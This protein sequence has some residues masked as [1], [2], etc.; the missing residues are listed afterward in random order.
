M[1][2]DDLRKIVLLYRTMGYEQVKP[3]QWTAIKAFVSG[4]DVYVALPTGFVKSLIY[5]TLPL[6]GANSPMSTL[7]CFLSF[8]LF[9]L[10]PQS[11]Q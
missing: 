1:M 4:V 11:R 10:T 8:S 3:E 2:A 7:L 9:V 5:A 6:K